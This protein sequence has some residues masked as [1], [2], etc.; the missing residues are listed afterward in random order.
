MSLRWIV[1]IV[2][3]VVVLVGFL[4]T[5][6]KFHGMK[7]LP[8]PGLANGCMGSVAGLWVAGVGSILVKKGIIELCLFAAAIYVLSALSWLAIKKL[9]ATRDMRALK[10]QIL[11]LILVFMQ[12]LGIQSLYFAHILKP[13]GSLLLTVPVSILLMI[14]G[15]F[16]VSKP[17]MAEA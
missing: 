3:T 4:F 11:G 9:L 12:A 5:R 15:V 8:L 14:L 1:I 17:K 10:I 16:C 7:S 2:C 13:D 6:K